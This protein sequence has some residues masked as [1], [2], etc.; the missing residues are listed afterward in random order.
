VNDLIRQLGGA[1]DSCVLIIRTLNIANTIVTF[2]P[3][4]KQLHFQKY[5]SNYMGSSTNL[6]KS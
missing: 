6:L 4:K 1:T 2:V 3:V 5:L